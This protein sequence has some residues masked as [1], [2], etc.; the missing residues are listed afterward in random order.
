MKREKITRKRSLGKE[1][2]KIYSLRALSMSLMMSSM[3]LLAFAAASVEIIREIKART[4]PQ[5]I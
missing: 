4:F 2:K 5:Y 1:S 3:S